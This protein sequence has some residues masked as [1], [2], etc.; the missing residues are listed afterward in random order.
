[1][2][3][4]CRVLV[5]PF[6]GRHGPRF[7]ER[8][9]PGQ[10]CWCWV[11][12]L[13]VA[14]VWCIM[15]SVP[16]APLPARPRLPHSAGRARRGGPAGGARCGGEARLLC[17]VPARFPPCLAA[18]PL[19]LL[20]AAARQAFWSWSAKLQPC[21]HTREVC[22]CPWCRRWRGAA[23]RT[24]RAS[25]R[26]SGL[27][28]WDHWEKI[29]CVLQTAS[30]TFGHSPSMHMPAN[31]TNV[32]SP[33]TLS[34]TQVALFFQQE[35]AGR[36]SRLSAAAFPVLLLSGDN[37]QVPAGWAGLCHGRMPDA[38]HQ[39]ALEAMP[40]GPSPSSQALPFPPPPSVPAGPDGQEP[41][42]AGGPHG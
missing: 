15:C 11:A 25:A 39:A 21:L 10:R 31:A 30:A 12:A 32:P 33:A 5:E 37:A 4:R 8:G 29:P 23:A 42:P 38:L 34:C 26:T 19:R 18:L 6:H 41:R 17:R 40:W 27:W 9:L 7:A 35:V 22:S 36:A 16:L 2:G 13:G 14:A 3:A 24:P 20:V 1:M 28:R